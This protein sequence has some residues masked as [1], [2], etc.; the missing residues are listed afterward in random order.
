MLADLSSALELFLP[1]HCVVCGCTGAKGS[2]CSVCR[3]AVGLSLVRPQRVD[4]L[5]GIDFPVFAAGEYG[6]ALARTIL[7]FKEQMRTGVLDTL[8]D[9]LARCLLEVLPA[10]AEPVVLL[11]L[12]SSLSSVGRRGFMPAALL[13]ED[14]AA[15]VGRQRRVLVSPALERPLRRGKQGVQKRAGVFERQRQ[16]VGSMRLARNTDFE[17]VPCLLL[18]DVVTTGASL[19]EAYR[20]LEGAGARCLGA[21]T[22]AWVPRRE[23]AEGEE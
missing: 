18:D 13:A 16:V 9:G 3:R 15:K 2:L 19:G 7:G 17:G 6:G 12:P 21:V 11:P 23:T 4:G 22:L 8:G 5:R 20:V 14:A 10:S 1:Q